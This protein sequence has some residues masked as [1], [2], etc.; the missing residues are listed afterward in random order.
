MADVPIPA[1][2]LTRKTSRFGWS[3]LTESSIVA[4]IAGV[5]LLALSRLDM[6]IYNNYVILADAFLHGHVWIDWPGARIDA[7]KYGG[8]YYIIE[9][10]IPAILLMP[11]VA[12]LGLRTNETTFTCLF[13]AIALG[14][15]WH[16][17]RTQLTTRRDNAALLVA[18]FAFGTDLA[19]C[20]I[21]GAVWFT[22]HIVADAFVFLALVEVFGRKRPWLILLLLLLA[23]GSRFA[24]IL[25]VPPL[26]VY[27][28]LSVPREKLVRV[29]AACVAVAI[30]FAAAYVAY[31]YARWG[32]PND[33]GYTEWYHG[34]Q[35]GEPTGSP[36][37]F[38]YI[39]YE[40]QSFFLDF[41]N[42]IGRYPW[43]V[44]GYSSVPLT[45]TS[46]ALI[47]AF[48]AG[49]NR[50]L[51]AALGLA[52]LLTFIPNVMYYANGGSQFGMRHALDFDPF[53]FALMVMA[54][55]AKRVPQWLLDVLCGFSILVGIWG[56]W[57]WR[58]FYDRMLN[59]ILPGVNG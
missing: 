10:P 46:P 58:T 40:L 18:F 21:Y 15:A 23:A 53:L 20:S 16:L 11:L 41:P 52:A 24:L 7:L 50:R 27:A 56:I 35:I 17:A 26:L 48:F 49:G 47:V 42:Y 9:G 39:P 36:F 34:D 38:E 51:I 32:V 44:I 22:A 31:N 55:A 14:A 54:V 30:P 8:A 37:R 1:P 13:G 25:A 59:H 19:W 28:L 2:V 33:I 3:P 45:L 43:L 5:I 6:T 29:L 4:I 57:F 12:I